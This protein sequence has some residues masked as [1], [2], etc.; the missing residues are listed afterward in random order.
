MASST[1]D[2]FDQITLAANKRQETAYVDGVEKGSQ[3][4]YQNGE[5]IGWKKGSQIGA[6]I[7]FY[8]GFV[9]TWL[10]IIESDP[11]MFI[12]DSIDHD[13]AK[14]KLTKINKCLLALQ[15][16]LQRYNT[17]LKQR[18]VDDLT[19]VLSKLRS[20]FKQLCSLLKYEYSN[21]DRSDLTY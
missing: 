16:Q 5:V 21:I 15:T 13:T 19:D 14:S 12:N 2:F 3:V 8:A 7:G 6:E 20:R 9:S 10:A 1:D 17:T 18:D 11:G 4:G